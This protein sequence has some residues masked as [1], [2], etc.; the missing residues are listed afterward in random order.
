MTKQN[1]DLLA[2]NFQQLVADKDANVSNTVIS[3]GDA[4]DAQLTFL[5]QCVELWY[6]RPLKSSDRSALLKG[7]VNEEGII[8]TWKNM[9]LIFPKK[10]LR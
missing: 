9:F 4:W 2:I 8:N 1:A 3:N 10:H 5:H 7:F 6:M